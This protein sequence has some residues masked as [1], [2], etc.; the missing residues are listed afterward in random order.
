MFS[1]ILHNSQE[2]TRTRVSF[3]IKLQASLQTFKKKR[4]WHRCFPLTFAKFLRTLS[5]RTP[6]VAASVFSLQPSSE[7]D[8]FWKFRRLSR[9]ASATKF[10]FSRAAAFSLVTLLGKWNLSSHFHK[11]FL[12]FPEQQILRTLENGCF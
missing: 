1:G 2:G 7:G 9:K 6:P 10:L 11:S 3:L 8:E 12:K 4:L 5:Y